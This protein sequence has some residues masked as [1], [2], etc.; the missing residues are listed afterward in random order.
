[1][2]KSLGIIGPN[3]TRHGGDAD[4]CVA[5]DPPASW[6]PFISLFPKQRGTCCENV[7]LSSVG[8]EDLNF[9]LHLSLKYYS[10][11]RHS[12][13]YMYIIWVER[14]MSVMKPFIFSFL[15][16]ESQIQNF[17]LV[18]QQHHVMAAP[19]DST[20][21]H[22]PHPTHHLPRAATVLSNSCSS[23]QPWAA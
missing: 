20:F 5:L 19:P 17:L 4:R 3:S 12:H 18:Y 2:S 7:R 13:G 9:I 16:T 15:R 21:S 22:S 8:F 1:M 14:C 10:A 11:I 6:F 23:P